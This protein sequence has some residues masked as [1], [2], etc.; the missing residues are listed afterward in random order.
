M[1]QYILLL[2]EE[3]IL[4]NKKIMIL[5]IFLVSL[6]A[7][8]AVCAADNTTNDI[9]SADNDKDGISLSE[10]SNEDE[11]TL[12]SFSSNSVEISDDTTELTYDEY[13]YDDD[14]YDD[15][16][17]DEDDY[18]DD[19]YD[20]D[21][22]D[23]NDYDNVYVES[24]NG[25]YGEKNIIKYGWTGNLNGYFEIYKGNTLLYQKELYSNGYNNHDET[26]DGSAIKSAGTYKAQICDEYDD[27][28]AQA[29]IKINKAKTHTLARSFSSKIGS[30]E[31]IIA[32]ISD[33]NEEKIYETSGT[34]KIKIAGKTYTTK[35]KKGLA[36][37][38]IKLP[39][40]AK[41]YKCTVKFLGNSNYKASSGKF[42]IKLNN[43]KVVILKKNKQVKVG[44]YT[45][46]LK[47]NHY[48]SLVKAFNKDKSKTL[49]F[50]TKYKY[51]VKV[52]YTKTVKKYKTTKAVKT[53]YGVSYLPMINRM[54]SNGWTKVSEYTYTKANPQNKY[55]IGLSAYTYAVCKWVKVSYKTAYK[56]KYYPVKAYISY[57]KSTTLPL[58][59]LY[60]NGRTITWKYMAIA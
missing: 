52:P 13:D 45:V 4:L 22:Y 48:K 23:E 32:G 60:A 50:K 40:K 37:I 53:L 49:D 46:K 11:E 27:I 56:T 54:Y 44:K 6:L 34:A 35:F 20:D 36:Y 16:Y 58:I 28:L 18:G 26:Y 12:S 33:P 55:G 7:V 21:Y 10:I 30:K 57:K 9:A 24:L 17:Y 2:L 19:Y 42:T 1:Y 31:Y 3:I 47:S 41:T 25:N 38:L 14:Y 8:S 59:E 29:T 5:T 43:G 51:K 15:S 39:L